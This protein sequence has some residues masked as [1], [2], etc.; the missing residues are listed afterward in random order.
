MKRSFAGLSLALFGLSILLW[1]ALTIFES[2]LLGVSPMVERLLTFFLLV[3]PSGIGAVL[4]ILSLTRN[5]G[6]RGLAIAGILCNGLFALFILMI[7]FFA[8]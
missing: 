4:G 6:L 7:L 2:A 1:L 8:G 3:M 5:E